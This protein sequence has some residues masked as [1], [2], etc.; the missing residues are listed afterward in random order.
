[1]RDQRS[2]NLRKL[3]VGDARKI[4]TVNRRAD[5]GN[6][7]ADPHT[8]RRSATGLTFEHKEISFK[9]KYLIR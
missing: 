7:A 8:L 1:M 3:R 4:N 2:M 5:G 9:N 6:D